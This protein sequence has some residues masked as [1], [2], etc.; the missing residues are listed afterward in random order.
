MTKGLVDQAKDK[1]MDAAKDAIKGATDAAIDNL[2]PGESNR[3]PFDLGKSLGKIQNHFLDFEK[4]IDDFEKDIDIF[5][6]KI[7]ER[8]AFKMKKKKKKEIPLKVI[9]HLDES[10]E[11][12]YKDILSSSNVYQGL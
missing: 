12:F 6:Q 4:D 8:I 9:S 11:L 5:E 2:I 7:L 10:T 1:V 3:K